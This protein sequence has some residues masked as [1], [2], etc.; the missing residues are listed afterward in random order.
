VVVVGLGLRLEGASGLG[1]AAALGYAADLLSGS[2]L[3]QH[4]LLRTLV[5]GATR[6]AHGKLNLG[7]WLSR[8][9]LVGLLGLGNGLVLAGLVALFGGRIALT[10]GFLGELLAHAAINAALAPF[11]LAGVD[12]A[13]HLLSADDERRRPLR[14]RR[15]GHAT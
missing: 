5:Y 3:G 1:A 7:G 11:V 6:I 2:L 12:A 4:A 8:A 10:P 9:L 14:L 13:A 15:P